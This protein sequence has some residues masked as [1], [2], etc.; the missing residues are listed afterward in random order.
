ML[1]SVKKQFADGT[2]TDEIISSPTPYVINVKTEQVVMSMT[3]VH[4]YKYEHIYPPIFYMAHDGKRY[5]MPVN[6][7]VHPDT[8]IDDVI[9]TK[10]KEKKIIIKIDGSMGEYKT[11]YDPN[12]KTYKCSCMGFWRSKGNCKHV[13]ALREKNLVS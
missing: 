12:K 13:K 7:E 2:V 5:L 1:Y 6:I 3:N 11:I 10:P 8:T 9:W 4:K